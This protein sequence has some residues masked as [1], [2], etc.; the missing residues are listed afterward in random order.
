MIAE[1]IR[2]YNGD[3]ESPRAR[4]TAAS[5]LYAAVTIRPP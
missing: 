4:S 5:A 2:K 1:M 3:L